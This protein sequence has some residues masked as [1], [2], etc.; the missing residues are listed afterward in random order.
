MSVSTFT[1]SS[2]PPALLEAIFT[3]RAAL[4]EKLLNRIRDGIE[5]GT[6]RSFLLTGPRGIGKT[7]L[8]SLL[9]HRVMGDPAL[10]ARL[11]VAWLPEDPYG[12][13]SYATLLREILH[14]LNRQ[15]G[16]PG[17]PER[18]EEIK[19]LPDDDQRQDVL[20][21]VLIE[22]LD[23]KPLF[24]I[25]ENLDEI[26]GAL[27][28]VGQRS[29]RALLQSRISAILLC[30]TTSLAEEIKDRKAAFHGF[31]QI[32]TL[33]PF[34]FE[35]CV[36]ILI[37]LANTFGDK[38]LTELLHAPKGRARV[39]AVH[40]L[41]GGNPR[42]YVL[43]FDF[44]T[45]DSLDQLRDAFLSLLDKLTPYYQG[46][47]QTLS[48]RQRQYIEVIRK[49]IIPMAVRDIARDA[50]V[51]PNSAGTDL[52][53]LRDLGYVQ[54]NQAGR[55]SLYEL[56]EPLMRM[57]LAVKEER[58][59]TV[60]LFVDFLRVWFLEGDGAGGEHP[61]PVQFR[62]DP[63]ALEAAQ[64]AMHR[65]KAQIDFILQT[66]MQHD[67]EAAR[68]RD[69]E[70]RAEETL[71][72]LKALHEG[73]PGNLSVWL[74]VDRRL[75][76][77]RDWHQ[78]A[79]WARRLIDRAPDQ[80]LGWDSLRLASLRLDNDE[81]ALEATE[82]LLILWPDAPGV[83]IDHLICL[84]LAGRWDD[85]RA[86]ARQCLEVAKDAEAS[87]QDHD[88]LRSW[89]VL[90]VDCHSSLGDEEVAAEQVLDI[91]FSDA[92]DYDVW[93]RLLGL[94]QWL[95]ADRAL[96]AATTIGTEHFPLLSEVWRD[97][98]V[99]LAVNGLL[100]EALTALGRAAELEPVYEDVPYDRFVV[101]V[102]TGALDEARAIEPVDLTGV[103]KQ[104][105]PAVA[106]CAALLRL[107]EGRF[108]EAGALLEIGLEQRKR[109]G[110]LELENTPLRLAGWTDRADT[111]RHGAEIWLETYRAVDD[112]LRFLG[113]NLVRATLAPDLRLSAQQLNRWC[114]IWQAVAEEEPELAVPLRLMRAAVHFRETLDDAVLLSLPVE[115]RA[116]LDPPIRRYLR[117][118]GREAHPLDETVNAVIAKAR[119][120]HGERQARRRRE[121]RPIAWTRWWQDAPDGAMP[122]KARLDDALAH[123]SARTTVPDPLNRLAP[124]TWS[125][126]PKKAASGFLQSLVE[127]VPD[128]AKLLAL[129]H[130]RVLRIEQTTLA[131]LEGHLYQLHL[132][133][134]SGPGALDVWSDGRDWV[135]LDGLASTIQRLVSRGSIVLGDDALVPYVVFHSSVLRADEGRFW[136]IL[137][138]DAAAL[139][140]LRAVGFELDLTHCLAET[141]VATLPSTTETAGPT[142]DL[143][144][145][146]IYA[147]RPWLTGYFVADKSVGRVT[148]SYTKLL[149]ADLLPLRREVFAGPVRLWEPNEALQAD[150]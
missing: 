141:D 28:V 91:L 86:F 3:A 140:Q 59:G 37:R 57:C 95:R 12:I 83:K 138:D 40:H 23:G 70:D 142:P 4:A 74:E 58:G 9:H 43:F 1:P 78:L 84:R 148:I 112:G 64:A 31:F 103:P 93:N 20:E 5:V 123:Y 85:A 139:E 10:A 99:A 121:D 146:V 94:L 24:L 133:T 72:K 100:T 88:V 30:T 109:F 120:A 144:A 128:A 98:A 45:Q 76:A 38:D 87:V 147:N 129:P 2:M 47:M 119:R 16:V 134:Q 21:H 8:V 25:A 48:P 50:F 32:E 44:L 73:A 27:D 42:V 124:G 130:I 150:R 75:T 36:G 104:A 49:N 54:A 55:E 145:L 137:S 22:T 15:H 26:L 52:K 81:V 39:R 136:T 101:L 131:V 80:A 66:L 118:L 13:S 60:P 97:H 29:L 14:Q 102:D 34:S 6:R 71:V 11:R 67:D 107:I 41:A 117:W 65:H 89:R 149:T 114:D 127:T 63:A 17:W 126:L 113:A 105:L 110:R 46:R 77:R 7:F 108:D 96:L 143:R 132:S 122:T 82:R 92:T 125:A 51:S 116:L 135:V 61:L 35:D 19:R 79:D 56:R 18:L 115:E 33:D 111:L 68:G 53:R 106:S 90:E 69:A 62:R